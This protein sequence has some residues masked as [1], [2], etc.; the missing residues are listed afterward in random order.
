W[1]AMAAVFSMAGR[2]LLRWWGGPPLLDGMDKVR[3]GARPRLPVPRI[4][5]PLAMAFV[6]V[7]AGSVV[8]GWLPGIGLCRLFWS[9]GSRTEASSDSSDLSLGATVLHAFEPPVPQ[10]LAQSLVLGI[11]V[12]AGVI[13][14]AWLLRPDP[15]ARLSAT[16]T[17]RFVGRFAL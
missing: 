6:S 1:A 2:W 9:I 16:L 10:L 7:L 4:S 13:I 8:I 17:T 11:E 12:A 3:D 14:L 5:M 15:G